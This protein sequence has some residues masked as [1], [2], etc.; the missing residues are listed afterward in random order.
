MR[1]NQTTTRLQRIFLRIKQISEQQNVFFFLINVF[2]SS[3]GSLSWSGA[4]ETWAQERDSFV[5]FRFSLSQ[6]LASGGRVLS[7][8][9]LASWTRLLKKTRLSRNSLAQLRSFAELSKF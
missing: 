1:T 2:I 6:S 7:G 4:R 8:S 9:S 5:M 3:Y